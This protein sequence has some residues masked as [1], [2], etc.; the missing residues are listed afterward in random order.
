MVHVRAEVHVVNP[1]VGTG[2]D[3]NSITSIGE[4]LADGDVA[5]DDVGDVLD[6]Q[7]DAFQLGARVDTQNRLVARDAGL[8]I[9]ADGAR[10]VNDS[11]TISLSC[12]G[13][14]REGGDGSGRASSATSRAVVRQ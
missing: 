9:T 2:L 13:E 10:Y 6:V 14:S 11:C 4:N 8:A 1:D 7:T 3:T 12:F 5:N